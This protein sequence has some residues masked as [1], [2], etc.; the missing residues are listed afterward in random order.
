VQRLAYFFYCPYIFF[1][2]VL[3]P[4]EFEVPDEEVIYEVIKKSPKD[5]IELPLQMLIGYPTGKNGWFRARDNE[6]RVKADKF[7]TAIAISLVSQVFVVSYII[8]RW[9]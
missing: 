1:I 9:Y 7:R 4:I 8:M 3:A 5:K 2:Q 6:N